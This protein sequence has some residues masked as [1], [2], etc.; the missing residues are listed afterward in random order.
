MK[1]VKGKYGIEYLDIPVSFDIETS[2]FYEYK[3]MQIDDKEICN[4][5]GSIKNIYKKYPGGVVAVTDVIN[6]GRLVLNATIVNPI[7]CS[8]ICNF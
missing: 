5:D 8:L 1:T 3:G 7:N 2:N 4:P 6:S